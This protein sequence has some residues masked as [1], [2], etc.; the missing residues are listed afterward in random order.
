MSNKLSPGCVIDV[1]KV[2]LTL[3]NIETEQVVSGAPQT[4]FVEIGTFG[5]FELGIWEHTVGTSTDTETDEVFIVL[6]GKA[7]VEF[8][9]TEKPAIHIHAGSIV[10]LS[11]GME[12]KWTVEQTLRKVYLVA[13]E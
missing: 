6:A 5:N 8:L 3:E 11:E 13:S 10:Q 9:N 1:H 4:G 12:T 7:I 2:D